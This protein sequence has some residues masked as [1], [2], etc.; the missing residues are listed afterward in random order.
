MKVGWFTA[1]ALT[2]HNIPE[3]LLTFTSALS[4]KPGLGIGIATAIG[5]HNIPEGFAVAFPIKNGTK[6]NKKVR[7][8][9]YYKSN[10]ISLLKLPWLKIHL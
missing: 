2:L 5:L 7:S 9:K 8:Y 4:E 6:S 1:L 3:G 10:L